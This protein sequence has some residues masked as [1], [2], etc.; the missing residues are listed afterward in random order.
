[1]TSKFIHKPT[2]KI[3]SCYDYGIYETNESILMIW[4]KVRHGNK[5]SERIELRWKEVKEII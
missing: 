1:M 5:P 3:Y 2:G 4:L